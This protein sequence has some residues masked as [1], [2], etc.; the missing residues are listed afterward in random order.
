MSA[1]SDLINALHQS[2][3]FLHKRDISAVVAAFGSEQPTPGTVV[4]AVPN[5]D[6]CAVLPDGHG[7]YQLFAIEGLVE[8][9]IVRMPWFAGY[10]AVMV[11]ISDIYAMGGRPVAVVNALWSD[12]IAQ[13]TDMIQGMASAC[14]RYG[15]PMVGG[16]SNNRNQ[17][18]ELAVAITGTA[19]RL[20]SSFQ[21]RPGDHLLMAV[22]LRGEWQS[23]FPYWNASTSA[24]SERL[25][26][27][28]A[29]LPELAESGLCDAAKDISMAGVIGTTLMML[30]CSGV[31][32][33]IYPDDIPRPDDVDML[34]WLTA[35]PSY[36]FVLSVRPEHVDAVM[37]RFTQRDLACAR[38]GV[39][40]ASRKCVLQMG[41]ERGLFWDIS[42]EHFITAP[43]KQTVC[44]EVDHA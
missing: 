11:N 14:A 41:Q 3:G 2:R 32:A 29:V 24:P 22:D 34:R 16:H 36:G 26:A 5:G 13:A 7:G 25:R 8:D 12:G 19:R 42:E 40:N 18:P 15:V 10:S 6:D 27:D 31:G 21:A 28:L 33:D 38:I 1:L 4:P 44:A 37:A 30:E 17:R 20:L 23:P 9:F 39:V 35:F 43:D